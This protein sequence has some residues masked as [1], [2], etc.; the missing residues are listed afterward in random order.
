MSTTF[1]AAELSWRR[2]RYGFAGF[3]FLSLLA[4]WFLLRLVLLI[5]FKPAGVPLTDVVLAL[6]SGFHRDIFAALAET[7]PLLAWMLIIPDRRFGSLWHRVLFIGACFV[8]GFVQIFLLFT[9]FFFFDEFKSRF[10]TVAVDYLLYPREVFINIWE[11]YHV[12]LVLAFCLVL[13]LGWLFAASRLVGQMWERP[14]RAKSRLLHLAAAMALAALLTP[15]VNLKSVHVSNDRTLNEIANNGAI[16]FL[17]AAWT[18]NLDYAAFYKTTPLDEAYQRTRRLLAEENTQYVEQG[19]AIRRCVAGDRTRP[20]LNVVIFLEE[21]LGSE[22]WGCLGR[23]NTLTPEMDKL[24][25]EGGMLFTNIYASGNR[26]VRGFEGVLSSFPPLPGESIVKRDRSDNV[27][28]IARVLKRDGYASVFLYGGRGLFD[29]MRSFAIRNG[30]DRFVEEKH[31]EH[32]TFT[33]IWGVCDEDLFLGAV[34]E[35]RELA[36]TGQPFCGTILSVSNHKPYTY[37]KGKI[38]E[39]PDQRRRENAAKYSDYA[40]GCFFKAARKEAF[41]TNTLFVVVADHGARVYGEQSIPIHSYE[42]PLLITGP[43]VVKSPSRVSQLGCSLD[44]PTTVL[45][46]LGRPYETMFFGRDLLRSRPEDGRALLNHNR[47]IGM[48]AH[49]RLVVLGLK[50]TVE[51]YQGDPKVAEMRP[52]LQPTDTDREL[53]QDAIALYQVADDLYMHRRYR[54][55]AEAAA[56]APAK[57]R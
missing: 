54:I 31:F 16:S 4:A 27:E 23:T 56:Q 41:W 55:D 10:N 11:S 42:I 51:F 57:V 24:A 13:S 44:V 28:T 7:I 46:L 15:T 47:D 18:H 9:E 48:L 40:L 22:F 30:Y 43:A 49:D 3:W 26:T 38:L 19:Q 35:F 29:G 39:D 20:R 5:A 34:D 21:S 32:P 33:T 17:A 52:L 14:F 1:P 53:E 12:V 8:F 6:L 2:S 36:K 45:G 25:A 50:Q 37:P